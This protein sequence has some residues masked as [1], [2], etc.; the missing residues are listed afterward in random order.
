MAIKKSDMDSSLYQLCD[1]LRGGMDPSQYKDYVLTL[2]FVK[3]ITDKF[4]GMK[5]APIKIPEG[6]SFEDFKAL[7][8]TANIG[9]EIDKA[10]AK[11]ANHPDNQKML[12]GMFKDVH[13]NDDAKI[14]KGEEMVKKLTKLI[15]IFCRPEFDFSKNKASGDDIL[16]DVYENLMKHFAVD[17][18][19]SKG[20]FYT[21]AEAS[22]VLAGVL[23]I[24][25]ITPKE[26]ETDGWTICDW[27]CGSGSLLIR[28]AHEAG[29]EVA[30]YGQELNQTTAALCK[31]NMV[32][33][34]HA[35]A[36][37]YVGNTF[38]D[39]QLTHVEDGKEVLDT[40]D[41]IVMNPP[42]SVKNWT[43]GYKDFGCSEG[44][45]DMP[46][47][48]NGDYAW[49]MRVMK[50]LKQTGRAAVILPLGVLFRGNAEGT[51]RK[52]L[53]DKGWIEGIIAFP[54]NIFFGT[55]IPAC[56]L[57][58][59][60]SGAA[61]RGG[62]FMIDASRDFVKDGEKNRLRERDIEKIVST[63]RER[64]VEAHYS[65]FV[66]WGEIKEKNG[67]NLNI[68]R[69]IDS[70]VRED[71]QDVTAHLKGGIPT[72][73]IDGLSKYW[74]AFPS[75]R[76]KLFKHLRKGYEK[77]RV[78]ATEVR[79][80]IRED[81]AFIRYQKRIEKAIKDWAA[82]FEHA[83]K[84]ISDSTIAK[85]FIK[86]QA[87]GLFKV[88]SKVEG[89]LFDPYDVY[90]VLLKYWMDVMSDDVYQIIDGGFAAG[91]EIDVFYKESENKK[92]GKVKKVETGW[93]GRI[94]SRAILDARFF[95]IEVKALCDAEMA[96]EAAK[97]AL[98]E[99]N[100][101]LASNEDAEVDEDKLAAL[102]KAK[103]DAA[104]KQK[105]AAAKL[106]ALEKAKYPVL[107]EDELQD[108]IVRD[109][110]ITTV[111]VGIQNLYTEVSNHLA[112][113]IGVLSGRYGVAL[114]DINASSEAR[115]A[116]VEGDFTSMGYGKGCGVGMDSSKEEN[117]LEESGKGW[118][119]ITLEE[120]GDW[121]KGQPLAK[122]DLTPHG[123]SP[124]I[125]Y[126]ELFTTYGAIIENVISRTDLIPKVVSRV[127]D[128]LFPTSDVT[129]EGLGRCS[130]IFT[131]GVILGGDLLVLR[132]RI[133]VDSSLLSY[134]INLNKRKIIEQVTGTTVRHIS[135]KGLGRITISLPS[136][137]EE[138]RLIAKTLSNMDMAIM[139]LESKR[140]KYLKI[141][142]GMM[143]DLLTGKVRVK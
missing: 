93:D 106:E 120:I 75:L 105:S 100:A 62:V 60:K 76:A 107:K 72:A 111:K 39:P 20:Q 69:Y 85:D 142:Q 101:E 52:A 19:K 14:G 65:R 92:T 45:G 32:L 42:F 11:L 67:Y 137:I 24:S 79:E 88:F 119:E 130:A 139:G 133:D 96:V 61:A 78:Q 12:G 126:G 22:R 13:F 18:G 5:Y 27:A 102:E 47:E 118:C 35:D 132:P 124:C 70:G 57:I 121:F 26:D 143:N 80:T 58:L 116:V 94:I 50:S 8:N 28:A 140:E 86:E 109:K 15:N 122:S 115:D 37:I 49:L 81:E 34:G 68:P 21:P 104:K 43:D 23:G 74:N 114:P 113:R 136:T 4:L 71:F 59:S 63:Y 99:F 51:I 89:G 2:V 83:C 55:G 66:Q 135:S 38:S 129:P 123:R 25:D 134:V 41:F 84:E 53:V 77:L 30:I 44:Y 36:E 1:E 91:R 128:I 73:D 56:V 64:R 16:G 131:D 87:Q 138:Q 10:L 29:C 110:W 40:F 108:L 54:P 112:E 31:M 103:K 117:A 9:E 98:E 90:E 141:R 33:H 97:A 48:K 6:C 17:S 7:R 127:G 82:H 95:K 46:P 125:H 3:Y